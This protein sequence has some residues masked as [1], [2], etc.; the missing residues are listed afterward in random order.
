VVL[1]QPV[2]GCSEATLGFDPLPSSPFTWLGVDVATGAVRWEI[3]VPAAVGLAAG[4]DPSG[5]ARWLA[6]FDAGT[7]TVYDLRTGTVSGRYE[8]PVADLYAPLSRVLGAGDQL[9]VARRDGGYLEISAFDAPELRLRWHSTVP[10]PG[11]I[12]QVMAGI[13]ASPCGP[14]ICLGPASQTVGLD[15]LTGQERWRLP[16]RPERI[17]PGFALFVRVPRAHDQPTMTVHDLASGAERAALR[18]TELL[19][20]EWGDPLLNRS[21]PDGRLWRLDLADGHLRPITVLPGAF[22]DCDA[23]G[24]YLACRSSDGE[25]RVWRLPAAG[26]AHA[27]RVPRSEDRP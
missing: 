25:L 9:L 3:K 8:P 4:V 13:V 6:I 12:R 10:M 23:A 14:A 24:R 1:K 22:A 5:L 19:S 26:L 11:G 27:G 7:V 18:K 20:R 2:R 17:G 16:G 15:P 21:G